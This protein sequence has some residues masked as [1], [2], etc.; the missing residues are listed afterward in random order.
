VTSC[1]DVSQQ[2]SNEC[3]SC[4][5][6][7]QNG[8]CISNPSFGGECTDPNGWYYCQLGGPSGRYPVTTCSY[9]SGECSTC[10]DPTDE[11]ACVSNAQYGGACTNPSGTN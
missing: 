3:S 11:G 5:N 2:S 7:G 6:P 4:Y 9:N 10:Y 8:A 1:A